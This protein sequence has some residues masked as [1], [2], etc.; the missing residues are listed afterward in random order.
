MITQGEVL[1][2]NRM[3]AEENLDVRTITIGINL[4]DCIDP[5]P[6]NTCDRIYEKVTRTAEKL[7]ATGEEIERS[8]GIPIVNKRISVTPI[9]LIGGSAC[10]STDD[11]V[12][13][14][15]TLDRAARDTGVNFLGGYSALC[16]KGMT[17]RRMRLRRQVRSEL[18]LS[19]T[20][21]CPFSAKKVS[22]SA[23]ETHKSGRKI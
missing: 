3:I 16:S 10:R 20:Y 17:S 1:E 18:V 15:L 9:A 21:F 22:I 13:L 23:L 19:V 6:D 14:A 11:F 4:L 2:T 5:D 12:E 7:V 8:F